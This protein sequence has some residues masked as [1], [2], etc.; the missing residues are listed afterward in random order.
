MTYRWYDIV[1]S[2]GCFESTEKINCS[3]SIY[4]KKLN[5]VPG[6]LKNCKDFNKY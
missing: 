2:Y 6:F 4:L 1:N 3:L 5:I